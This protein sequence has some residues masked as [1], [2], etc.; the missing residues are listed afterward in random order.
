MACGANIAYGIA[1]LLS[2][3]SS[4]LVGGVFLL[5]GKRELEGEPSIFIS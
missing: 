1:E 2:D 3:G 4:I 5:T